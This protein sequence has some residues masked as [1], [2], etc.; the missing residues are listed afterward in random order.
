MN[1]TKK[2]ERKREELLNQ[3]VALMWERGFNGVSVRDVVQ[4]AGVPK[5][6]FYFY[7]DSKD[8]FAL[9]VLKKY[10]RVSSDET[11]PDFP[12]ALKSPLARLRKVYEGRAEALGKDSCRRGCMLV[13]VANELG[14]SNDELREFI[15]MHW[16]KMREPMVELV[17]EA[18]AQGEIDGKFDAKEL[19]DFLEVT[20]MGAVT[21]AKTSQNPGELKRTI[22][23]LFDQVLA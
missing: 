5:G 11:K 12:D 4:A 3:G 6:S 19:T 10:V 2:S 16:T 23:F 15:H 22:S 20:W 9:E 18:K 8:D 14:A 13:N 7:F 21:A 1:P 17:G